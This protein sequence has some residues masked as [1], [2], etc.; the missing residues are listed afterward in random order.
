MEELEELIAAADANRKF[1]QL[2]RSVRDGR[3]YVVTIH[4]KP[5]AKIIPIAKDD[6]VMAG[7]GQSIRSPAL[8]A[9]CRC[10]CWT[11]D[12]LYDDKS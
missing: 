12:E 1:S 7:R 5:V 2:L 9:G 11:R 3:T 8:P 10:G 4:G 6:K